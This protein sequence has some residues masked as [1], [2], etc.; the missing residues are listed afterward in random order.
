MSETTTRELKVKTKQ[1]FSRRAGDQNRHRH[2]KSVRYLEIRNHRR[3]RSR[4]NTRLHRDLLT[5][6]RKS[7]DVDR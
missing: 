5:P 6:H 3:R 7:L 4:A 1:R 2:S